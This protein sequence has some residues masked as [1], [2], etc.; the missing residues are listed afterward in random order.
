MLQPYPRFY[1]IRPQGSFVPL[2]PVDELPTWIQV[3]N[4]DW[5]DTSLFTAMAPASFSSI[6]RVGEYDVVCHHCNASL[7]GLHRSVSEQSGKTGNSAQYP[8]LPLTKLN[9]TYA[10]AFL[11]QSSQEALSPLASSYLMSLKQPL[12]Y[13]PG[14]PAGFTEPP[15]YA[16]LQSPFVGMCFIKGCY[17]RG[18]DQAKESIALRRIRKQQGQ[19]GENLLADEF[20]EDPQNPPAPP[21]LP[22]A[23][24]SQNPGAGPSGESQPQNNPAYDPDE[25]TEIPDDVGNVSS[26]QLLDDEI[27]ETG[28]SLTPASPAESRTN[29]FKRWRSKRQESK[30]QE[31]KQQESKQQEP[32]RLGKQAVQR[33]PVQ[34]SSSKSKPQEPNQPVSKETQPVPIPQKSPLRS[35]PQEPNHPGRQ[36]VQR[37]PVPGVPVSS[38]PQNPAREEPQVSIPPKSPLRSTPQEHDHPAQQGTQPIPIPGAS[39]RSKLHESNPHPRHK[40]DS[41]PNKHEELPTFPVDQSLI[42][43]HSPSDTS[44]DSRL[45]V[46]FTSIHKFAVATSISKKTFEGEGVQAIFNVL[47]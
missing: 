42:F 37:A 7:D 14:Y 47:T 9:Q 22:S 23:S 26:A 35:A 11:S 45:R 31:S 16:N 40:T 41:P 19:T 38:K 28:G 24:T 5:N 21:N 44:L 8:P 25:I 3:G 13:T 15:Y 20:P 46:G 34:A 12:F 29:K 30:K 39:S 6:P 10:G 4:W 32:P 27:Q 17:K 1:I 2:I 18:R 33:T 36:E 43:P